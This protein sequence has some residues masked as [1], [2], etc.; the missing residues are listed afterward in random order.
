MAETT[1]GGPKL[2]KVRKFLG[3]MHVN[4]LV[5]DDLIKRIMQLFPRDSAESIAHEIRYRMTG[6][7]EG[8]E[9]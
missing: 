3:D 1:Q 6:H 7:G 9:R 2:I 4:E 8:G 5:S